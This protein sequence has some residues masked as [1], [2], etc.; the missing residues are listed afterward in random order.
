MRKLI[1]MFALTFIALALSASALANGDGRGNGKKHGKSNAAKL[2]FKVASTDHGTCQ[3]HAW[4][5][6]DLKRTY[7][8]KKHK[9]GSYTL[10][11]FDRGS[12]VTLAGQSPGACDTTGAHG[13]TVKAGVQGRVTGYLRGTVTGGTFDKNATCTAADCGNRDVFLKTFFGPTAQ[14]SCDTNSTDCKFNYKYVAKKHAFKKHGLKKQAAENQGLLFHRW[15]DK[16]T[17]AGT[18]GTEVFNGDI[19]NA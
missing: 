5:T 10:V 3:T 17:G 12:F 18:L 13:Q 14:F 19:A 4:A 9:D 8:V 11:R 1:T 16:G 2:T 7:F 6:L 15:Q